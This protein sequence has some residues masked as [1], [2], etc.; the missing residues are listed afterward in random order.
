M[1]RINKGLSRHVII[2][3]F[4]RTGDEA[5]MDQAQRLAPAAGGIS[6]QEPPIVTVL[7]MR[8]GR[9]NTEACPYLLL[10]LAG[11]PANVRAGF[12]DIR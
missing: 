6:S 2:P 4:V 5:R 12:C 1:S 3:G 11:R 10:I 7:M 8:T 9:A